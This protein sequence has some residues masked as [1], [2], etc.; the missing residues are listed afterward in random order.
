MA[1]LQGESSN[2]PSL[3]PATTK[4]ESASP[5]RPSTIKYPMT[6]LAAMRA[7]QIMLGMV[8]I[9]VDDVAK[10]QRCLH[11]TSWARELERMQGANIALPTGIIA[12][13]E[14][15]NGGLRMELAKVG[16]VP[17]DGLSCADDA[18][19]FILPHFFA[20]SLQLLQH[21]ATSPNK[22]LLL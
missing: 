6:G 9:R 17:A 12:C 5:R 20:L 13:L 14:H 1:Q 18:A 16:T 22:L 7:M 15:E 11:F 10:E 2:L 3:T 21:D 8:Q 4:H 19:Q